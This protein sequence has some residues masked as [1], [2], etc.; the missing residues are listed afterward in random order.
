METLLTIASKAPWLKFFWNAIATGSSPS[1]PRTNP[2][3]M[4]VM[5]GFR[6]TRKTATNSESLKSTANLVPVGSQSNCSTLPPALK[7]HQKKAVKI[8]FLL[9]TSDIK[10]WFKLVYLYLREDPDCLTVHTF[11]LKRGV[12]RG[13]DFSE[14]SS[15]SQG[16]MS[17]EYKIESLTKM[18]LEPSGLHAKASTNSEAVFH[19]LER[20]PSSNVQILKKGTKLLVFPLLTYY[21]TSAVIQECHEVPTR[22]AKSELCKIGWDSKYLTILPP[23]FHHFEFWSAVSVSMNQYS[24]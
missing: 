14:I 12:T 5:V 3:A 17:N 15:I 20:T 2:Q 19:F 23:E 9:Q 13:S 4:S 18:I 7:W 11:K 8:V 16:F 1:W 22:K 24:K 10:C 6:W 21:S